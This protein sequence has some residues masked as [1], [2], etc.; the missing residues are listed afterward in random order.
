[1]EVFGK[2]ASW[3]LITARDDHEL[4]AAG[5]F[6]VSMRRRF[7]VGHIKSMHL[8]ET[9]DRRVDNIFT[10]EHNGFVGLDENDEQEILRGLLVLALEKKEGVNEVYLPGI[11]RRLVDKCRSIG[12]LEGMEANIVSVKPYFEV[13]LKEFQLSERRFRESISKN[14]RAKIRQSVRAYGASGKLII[15]KAVNVR[16]GLQ[17]FERLADLHTVRWRAK[18]KAGAFAS[19]LSR[20]FHKLLIT[21]GVAEGAVE[22]LRIR[23]GKREIGYLYNFIHNET[24]YSYQ[25]GFV[26]GN[27]NRHRPGLISH[28]MAI[29]SYIE[30]KKQIYDF[31]AGESQL[32][33][34]LST[35]VS[36]MYWL[37]VR[38]SS[39]VNSIETRLRKLKRNIFKKK[40]DNAY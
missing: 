8:Q 1:M 27:S 34:A 31:L 11:S 15:E 29:E 2:N 39:F 5:V 21:K 18:G 19:A 22:L 20:K 4:K 12:L 25:N 3:N 17:F 14:Y 33:R 32:K 28:V 23:A 38:R 40:P 13:N 30:E 16:Q 6:G 37:Q 9:G 24:C 36:P 10:I 35:Q 26:Y 7:R